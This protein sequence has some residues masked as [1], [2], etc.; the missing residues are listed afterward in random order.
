MFFIVTKYLI[1]KI[2]TTSITTSVYFVAVDCKG[3]HKKFII[4]KNFHIYE[5]L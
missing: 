1:N 3:T 5:F 2:S 4:K